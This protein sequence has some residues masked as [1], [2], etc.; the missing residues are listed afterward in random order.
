VSREKCMF[1]AGV[2]DKG[3]RG[4]CRPPGQPSLPGQRYTH[5]RILINTSTVSFWIIKWLLIFTVF[6]L[7]RIYPF[8]PPGYVCRNHTSSNGLRGEETYPS[9]CCEVSPLKKSIWLSILGKLSQPYN[10]H[11]V[12]GDTI[13]AVCTVQVIERK[14]SGSRCRRL[15]LAFTR[16][17]HLDLR[18]KYGH[19]PHT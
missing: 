2:K 13:L 11:A 15:S 5:L 14:M 8:F 9:L 1:F 3:M 6:V 4:M 18:S 10:N 17:M 7:W 16:M 19:S 12:I